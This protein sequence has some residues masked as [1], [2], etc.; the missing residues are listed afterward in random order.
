MSFAQKWHREFLSDKA[1]YI[2][3][4]LALAIGTG[5][6]IYFL[7]QPPNYDESFSF[8]YYALRP[9]K[10]G[11][12]DYTYPNNHLFHTFLSHVAYLFGGSNIII[13]RM[14]AFIAG[15]LLPAAIYALARLLS[16][17]QVA[18]MAAALS[19]AS[20]YLIEYSTNARGYSIIGLFFI[21]L[22]ITVHFIKHGNENRRL[23]LWI[24]FI[25]LSSLGIHTVPTMIYPLIIVFAWLGRDFFTAPGTFVKSKLFK[26]ILASAFFIFALSFILYLPVLLR[27]GMNAVMGN[28]FVK[29]QP[30]QEVISGLPE[31]LRGIWSG[32]GHNW[33]WP[34]GALV[35]SGFLIFYIFIF[36]E[37]FYKKNKVARLRDSYFLAF[38][39]P[40]LLVL[41]LF[42]QRVVPPPRVFIFALGLFLIFSAGGLDYFLKLIFGRYN[43]NHR[44]AALINYGL[45]SIFLV[46]PSAYL[47]AGGEHSL[48]TEETVIENRADIRPI[49][50]TLGKIAAHNGDTILIEGFHPAYLYYAYEYKFITPIGFD[51]AYPLRAGGIDFTKRYFFVFH[52]DQFIK[53]LGVSKIM[54]EEFLASQKAEK[55]HTPCARQLIEFEHSY[56]LS[57]SCRRAESD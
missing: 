10:D 27:F 57:L 34:L 42:L 24:L 32:W 21:L 20:G 15:I 4:F 28:K 35:F 1:H 29:S 31:T 9:L 55:I 36:Y 12:S 52:H 53:A 45:V 46:V 14:P 13:L 44:M 56:I 30:F 5:L 19:A 48:P 8:Y 54:E 23:R 7:S 18:L 43:V 3:L 17:K 33:I 50:A 2:F 25:I 49:V 26:K 51:P 16:G 37:I 38:S 40:P 39:A 6:R 47:L 11:L 41:F 22:L